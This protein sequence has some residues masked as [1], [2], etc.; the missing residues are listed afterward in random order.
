MNT[1]NPFKPGTSEFC[2]QESLLESL[3]KFKNR[4]LIRRKVLC[5]CIPALDSLMEFAKANQG[6]KLGPVMTDKLLEVFR[7]RVKW[8]L[9]FIR[10]SS[11]TVSLYW[12]RPYDFMS[13]PEF[14]ID[15]YSTGRENLGSWAPKLNEKPYENSIN[16]AFIA[17]IENMKE[18]LVGFLMEIE[19]YLR[20]EK[21][22]SRKLIKIHINFI[23][24]QQAM[25]NLLNDSFRAGGSILGAAMSPYKLFQPY[26]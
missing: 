7:M 26:R 16:D 23:K 1:K 6:K 25:D 13:S 24:S 12:S 14:S 21:M 8:E 22:E 4:M 19:N 11:L 9:E 10:E 3:E 15:F 17:C 2:A 20:K 18:S 5:V